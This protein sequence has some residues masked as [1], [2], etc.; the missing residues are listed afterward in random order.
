MYKR[1][2]KY[3][4]CRTRA[5]DGK[6]FDS[7]KEAHRYE[8]LLL[9]QKEGKITDLNT[10]VTYELIPPQHY[11]YARFSKNGRRL[12]D[13]VKLLE[14]GCKYIADF[15]YVDTATGERIVEDTKGFRTAE[16]IIKRKLMLFVHGIRIRE[17]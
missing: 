7:G 2:T 12:K 1:K 5:S 15:V 16:Y 9:L 4:N 10:Q 6:V 17:K 14:R 3:Y 13:G 8:E 11:T